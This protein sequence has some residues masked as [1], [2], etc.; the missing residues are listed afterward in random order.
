MAASLGALAKDGLRWQNRISKTTAAAKGLKARL[1]AR[2]LGGA[3]KGIY[4]SSL[5]FGL[6]AGA[7][8]MT[9]YGVF[10]ALARIMDPAAAAL[11]CGGAVLSALG[12]GALL[13]GR[14]RG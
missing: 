14:S 2:F 11:L 1:I 6:V 7:V 5:T 12:L 3:A 4:F 10:L 13:A 8:L 9:L